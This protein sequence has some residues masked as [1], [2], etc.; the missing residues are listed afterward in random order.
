MVME[1]VLTPHTKKILGGR[2]MCATEKVGNKVYYRLLCDA[3]NCIF[4][5]EDSP[6]PKYERDI[7]VLGYAECPRCGKKTE[8]LEGSEWVDSEQKTIMS[9]G[10]CNRIIPYKN[11]VWTQEV[12]SKHRKKQHR[13]FHKECWEKMFVDVKASFYG[14][15]TNRE[16][17]ILKWLIRAYQ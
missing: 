12:V 13:Y 6:D 2:G 7:K 9:C 5:P 14:L 10:K 3:S 1:F 17:M 11:I 8:Y 16:E 4:H 15:P